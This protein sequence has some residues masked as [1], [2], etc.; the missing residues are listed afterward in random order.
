MA[1]TRSS[2]R[3][4]LVPVALAL[5]CLGVSACGVGE[6]V[7]GADRVGEHVVVGSGT[8]IPDELVAH[9]YAGA[10]QR[11]GGDVTT[12]PPV[13]DRATL[14]ADLDSNRL[15]LVPQTSG[16]LLGYL[17]PAASQAEPD[18]VYVALNR[19]LPEGLSVSDFASAQQRPTLVVSEADARAGDISSI[20]DF[21]PHCATTNI[22]VVQDQPGVGVEP[23]AKT[24]GCRFATV[25]TYR[26]SDLPT[27]LANGEVQAALLPAGSPQVSDRR[28]LAL[29][30]DKYA[31]R[32][33]NVLPLFRTGAL[34][35]AQQRKLNVVAGELTTTDLADMIDQV[36]DGKSSADVARAWLDTHG[37]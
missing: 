35:E 27:A 26:P 15:T 25:R 24:Y 32:A 8:S 18:D 5:A 13:G 31:Y 23:L 11:A 17:E 10:V 12:A 30:D 28:F 6:P 22:G 34:T 20:E 9:I 14:L 1:R 21:A 3:H 16:D 29:T 4:R 37:V 7:G 36:Q 33:E 2:L 19:A